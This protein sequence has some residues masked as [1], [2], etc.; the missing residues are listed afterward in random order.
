M[1]KGEL[2]LGSYDL[3]KEL[4][5]YG[6]KDVVLLKK[7]YEAV[8]STTLEDVEASILNF[9]TASQYTWY[10]AMKN[11]PWP[12]SK[13][14]IKGL[15]GMKSKYEKGKF[16]VLDIVNRRKDE[17]RK[18]NSIIGGK[19]LPRAIEWK[20]S[21]YDETDYD[22]ITD[23][24]VMLDFKSMYPWAIVNGFFGMGKYKKLSPGTKEWQA[25]YDKN[26]EPMLTTDRSTRPSPKD[27]EFPRDHAIVTFSIHMSELEPVIPGV[28]EE[29]GRLKWCSGEKI[30]R[31]LSMID[32]WLLIETHAE[33]HDIGE[34]LAN[35]YTGNVY[36]AWEKRCFARKE[37]AEL[38]GDK[39]KR[40]QAKLSANALFGKTCS[41]DYDSEI[42]ICGHPNDLS[43][44]HRTFTWVSTLNHER[45]LERLER[46]EDPGPLILEGRRKTYSNYE[47]TKFPRHHGADILA[48]SRYLLW[49]AMEVVNPYARSG[50]MKSIGYQILY[51]DTDSFAVHLSQ[52]ARLIA[53]G[54]IH[55]ELGGL[56]DDLGEKGAKPGQWTKILRYI[57]PRPKCYG[58]DYIM[59][60][61]KR[62]VKLKMAAISM[63]ECV[64]RTPSGEEIEKLT[65]DHLIDWVHDHSSDG[66]NEEEGRVV[67]TMPGKMLRCGVRVTP[68]R[69][70]A[71]NRVFDI[72]RE[73]LRRTLFK[74]TWKGRYVLK[75]GQVPCLGGGTATWTVPRG[76]TSRDG[77]RFDYE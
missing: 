42:V 25:W 60:S 61:G 35:E 72:Y 27:R 30:T 29:N 32:I 10:G 31:S 46:N 64:F 8:D 53:S 65:L 22:K 70:S 4:H 23:A 54:L 1:S 7:L 59:P 45:W 18:F 40:A 48:M 14:R 43:K 28:D 63:G 44:F 55:D 73:D 67:V 33:I 69:A 2:E 68:S 74:T 24:Y 11:V 37:K 5:V 6:K 52:M 9:Q 36:A 16:R 62:G 34:V 77:V 58:F 71:G 76:W 19:T 49:Q 12:E 56:G 75:P 38:D 13:A 26:I 20:S 39:A 3:H 51:G 21:Q 57:G 41:R 47:P 66:K 15:D 17:D 50:A